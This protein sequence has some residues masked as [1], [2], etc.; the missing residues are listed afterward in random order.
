[1]TTDFVRTGTCTE[2]IF[3][4]EVAYI[5]WSERNPRGFFD[6]VTKELL[7]RWD[8]EFIRTAREVLG[9]LVEK[10]GQAIEE[11]EE[12]ENISCQCSDDGFSDLRHHIVG[13]G[14]KEYKACMKDPMRAIMRGR[15]GKYQESFGYCLPYERRVKEQL[16]WEEARAKAMEDMEHYE[17]GPER[18]A[19]VEMS[20]HDYM[21][22]DRA[23]LEA[24][25]YAAWAKRN[26][27]DLEELAASPYADQFDELPEVLERVR[28]IA[29]GKI[30]EVLDGGLELKAAV[31]KLRE[32]REALLRKLQ[33]EL[34]V[35]S[36]PGW[37]LDNMV[38]DALRY[39]TDHDEEAA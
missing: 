4:E 6:R 31:K 30:V 21:H 23:K 37:S 15:K 33:D 28:E 27:V 5:G 8:D 19:M 13:L 34:S 7:T 12:R 9:T 39:L 22:G 2:E 3:W 26:L 25:Y 17:P 14:K 38:G 11:T 1:M 35:L 24:G 29:D 10:L 36:P 16:S 32:E 18:D 20:A